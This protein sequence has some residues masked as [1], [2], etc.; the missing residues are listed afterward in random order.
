MW[1]KSQKVNV[2][3]DSSR[4]RPPG[5][6][7]RGLL[8]PEPRPQQARGGRSARLGPL[9]AE[10]T[11]PSASTRAS[12]TAY[13]V[14]RNCP[15]LPLDRAET[16]TGRSEAAQM[17]PG[18]LITFHTPWGPASTRVPGSPSEARTLPFGGQDSL[19]RDG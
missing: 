5:L 4:G 15:H 11:H 18:G 8:L 3:P 10:R 19:Q 13:N 6:R 9:P 1:E 7:M 2:S 14:T 12:F 17:Q 16:R